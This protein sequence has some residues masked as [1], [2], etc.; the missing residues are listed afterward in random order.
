[1]AVSSCFVENC[2]LKLTLLVGSTV[3]VQEGVAVGV[4]GEGGEVLLV[5]SVARSVLG[6]GDPEL[7]LVGRD[8]GVLDGRAR[9]DG[10]TT[11][12]V[13]SSGGSASGGEDSDNGLG[14]HG[15]GCW[16]FERRSSKRL[17]ECCRCEDVRAGCWMLFNSCST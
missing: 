1:M 3:G 17:E 7:A 4:N 6:V 9:V 15:C 10:N 8:A 14:E 13:G 11:E 12:L 16:K 2:G 5:A